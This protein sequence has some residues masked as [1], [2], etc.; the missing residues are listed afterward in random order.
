MPASICSTFAIV[1]D[2]TFNNS[3]VTVTNVR[4]LRVVAMTVQAVAGSVVTLTNSTTGNA[5]AQSTVQAPY[6]NQ[7]ATLDVN[8]V[9][10][11]DFLA[12]DNLVLTESAGFNAFQVV[13]TCEAINPEAL[14]V[15]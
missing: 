1:V 14:T 3:A 12:T 7:L 13:I 6:L 5:A 2:E 11:L 8:G 15:T 4:A 9:G 10:V